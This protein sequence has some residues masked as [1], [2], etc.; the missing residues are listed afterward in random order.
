M[1][2]SFFHGKDG[3]ASI[4]GAGTVTGITNWTITQVNEPAER[5]NFAT[6]DDWREFIGGLLSY[7]G[8]ISGYL[9]T[10]N[11]VGIVVNSSMTFSLVGGAETRAGTAYLTGVTQTVNYEGPTDFSIT[12]QGTGALT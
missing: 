3:T 10:T 1:A 2:N 8:E 9:D 4:T 5:T 7:T 12:F 11:T 6:G